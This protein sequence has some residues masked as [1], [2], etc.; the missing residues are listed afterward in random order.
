MAKD[1]CSTPPWLTFNSGDIPKGT[2]HVLTIFT[3]PKAFA[4][5]ATIVQDNAIGS[6]TR[7]GRDCEIILIGDDPGV[8]AA[9]A[10]HKVRYEPEIARNEQG[11][12]V[13]GELFARM[14]ALARHPLLALVN[15]DI[16]LVDDLLPA[17][18]TAA[19]ARGE[20]LGVASR[21]NCR[22]VEPLD[23]ARGW[24][25]ALRKR[26]R[27]ENSMYPA[28]GSDI[29]VYPRGLF[30]PVPPF[31]IGRGYW[32][33]WLMREAPRL[34]AP[35]IDLTA[36]ATTVHQM[37]SYDTVAGVPAQSASD[38]HVYETAEGRRNLALAGGHSQ[39]YTVYDASLIMSVD[40]QLCASWRP[41][42]L[43]RR[44]KASLRRLRARFQ[45]AG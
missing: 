33:N 45:K 44:I 19:R 18:A 37:H 20:F 36:A 3:L 26:A 2:P 7:L 40:L 29:F 14:N 5:Q 21:F 28:G 30:G 8:A 10:R 39:L 11:T 32:D 16:I 13:I 27:T 4:G 6:W 31:A 25:T 1:F 35:L 12:P 23:F 42:L 24:N 17:I 22:I 9:A 38:R 41:F 43:W 34:G 15:A